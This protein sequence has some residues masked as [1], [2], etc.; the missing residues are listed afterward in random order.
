MNGTEAL[1]QSYIPTTTAGAGGVRR[2]ILTCGLVVGSE[3]S[4]GGGGGGA[5]PPVRWLFDSYCA[6]VGRKLESREPAK[7][8]SG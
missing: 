8:A 1:A 7:P 3:P 6:C 2:K 4:T 5:L